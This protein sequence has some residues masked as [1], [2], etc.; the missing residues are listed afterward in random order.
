MN[1]PEV[2]MK[3]FLPFN[4]DTNNKIFTSAKWVNERVTDFVGNNDSRLGK[5]L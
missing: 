1:Y 4:D 3:T 2:V 5:F